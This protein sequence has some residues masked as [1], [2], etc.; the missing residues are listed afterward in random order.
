MSMMPQKTRKNHESTLADGNQAIYLLFNRFRIIASRNRDWSS[1]LLGSFERG[2][3][4][5]DACCALLLEFAS[6]NLPYELMQPYN[7]V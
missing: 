4:M 6:D 7:P 1:N 2:T 5:H 3:D